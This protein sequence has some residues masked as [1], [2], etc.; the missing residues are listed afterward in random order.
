M[1]LSVAGV[2]GIGIPRGTPEF[3]KLKTE[4]R[5]KWISALKRTD[6][7]ETKLKYATICDKH[8]ITGKC[9]LFVYI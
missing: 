5:E 6:L 7:T 9:T 3:I 4:R 1:L 8:F 2:A